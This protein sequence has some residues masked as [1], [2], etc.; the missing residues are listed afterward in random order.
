M[1][2]KAKYSS[3]KRCKWNA[4]IAG[5][6]VTHYWQKR[7]EILNKEEENEQKRV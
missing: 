3:G 5:Y 6:C 7:K 1:K 4:V 2:C